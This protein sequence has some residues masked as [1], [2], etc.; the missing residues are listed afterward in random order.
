M[1]PE[2]NKD[3]VRAWRRA[4]GLTQAE[5]G[6]LLGWGENTVA[7]IETGRRRIS[8]PEALLLERLFEEQERGSSTVSFEGE[9]V[10]RIIRL[11]QREGFFDVSEWICAKIRGGLR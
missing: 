4:Q 6:A 1:K 10:A 11:A 2:I 8:G 5:F 3:A 7:K 9:D